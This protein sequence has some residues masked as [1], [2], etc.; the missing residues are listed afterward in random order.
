[1]EESGVLALPVSGDGARRRSA[2]HPEQMLLDVVGISKRFGGREA[3]SDVSL[4]LRRGEILGIIGPNGAG[5]TTLL[6]IVSGL[7]MP[8]AGSVLLAGADITLWTP[9]R[10]AREG[11]CRRFRDAR[12]FPTLT[13]EEIVALAVQQSEDAATAGSALAPWRPRRSRTAAET[14]DALIELMRLQRYRETVAAD[15]STGTRRLVDLAC[16]IASAPQ[17]LLL[18]E[19]ATGLAQAETEEL[20]PILRQLR[21]RLGC[22]M[23]VVEHDVALV[24]ALADQL[25][26]LHL[27]RVLARGTSDAVLNDEA[28]VAA[29]LGHGTAASRSLVG[30]QP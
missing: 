8:D 21:S 23:V 22:A 12:L 5:K 9:D 4:S 19:P 17:L 30:A 28:V 7:T 26:A 20:E 29:Y 2:A 15:L 3:L 18:D 14:V 10:R 6:D 1:M 11:V 25:M 16:A 24:S 13:V 27:G